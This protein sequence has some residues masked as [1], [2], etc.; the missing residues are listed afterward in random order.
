MRGAGPAA[1]AKVSDAGDSSAEPQSSSTGLQESA[2]R[3]SLSF[4]KVMALI[5]RELEKVSPA[6]E[7]LV[8][9][10]HRPHS[11]DAVYQVDAGDA[12]GLLTP[13]V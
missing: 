12:A 13:S 7:V 11:R 4:L 1:V 8:V 10:P 2:F 6:A 5:R 3:A 9:G